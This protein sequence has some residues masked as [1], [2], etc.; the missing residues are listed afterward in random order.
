[1]QPQTMREVQRP[2]KTYSPVMTPKK[3]RVGVKGNKDETQWVAGSGFRIVREDPEVN[4]AEHGLKERATANDSNGSIRL[5]KFWNSVRKKKAEHQEESAGKAEANASMSNVDQT[6]AAGAEPP[7]TPSKDETAAKPSLQVAEELHDKL[8]PKEPNTLVSRPSMPRVDS[9]IL[10]RSPP[11]L[12]SPPLASTLFF[13]S[14]SAGILPDLF[15]NQAGSIGNMLPLVSVVPSPSTP[16]TLGKKKARKTKKLKTSKP[17]PL[18]PF[19]SYTT[20]SLDRTH[21]TKPVGAGTVLPTTP[22]R[23]SKAA[24]E[25]SSLKRAGWT[26]GAPQSSSPTS[27]VATRVRSEGRRIGRSGDTASRAALSKVTEII[28]RS[29]S[30]RNI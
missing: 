15:A 26:T 22:P 29:Y 30:E 9:S 5:S 1:M 25:K 28:S 21:V 17:P 3:G 4:T 10:P 12:M 7:S 23:R 19:P 11:L 8:S 2:H 24:V 20:N 6:A 13:T 18:L 16:V 14:P 27:L